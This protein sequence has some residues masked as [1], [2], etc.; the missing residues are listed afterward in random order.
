[1]L[2]HRR[3]STLPYFLTR[4]RY[5]EALLTQFSGRGPD[6]ARMAAKD[7]HRAANC[8]KA[9]T[10]QYQ[11]LLDPADAGGTGHSGDRQVHFGFGR[12]V[13]RGADRSGDGGRV[14]TRPCPSIPPG[15]VC[16]CG[17]M[18]PLHGRS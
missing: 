15:C 13:A 4:L 8:R 12:L 18:P 6:E 17:R 3:D 5:L 7:L 9:F 1:M 11:G 10:G 2:R 16:G 14:A